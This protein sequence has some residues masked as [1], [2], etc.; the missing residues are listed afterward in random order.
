MKILLLANTDWFL[1][2]FCS[3][4]AQALRDRGDELVLASPPGD[5]VEKLLE[6]GFLWRPFPM[7]RRVSNPFAE[8]RTLA[9]LRSLVR[10]ERPDLVHHFTLKCVLYGTL[11]SRQRGRHSHRRGT[12]V[13]VNSITGLGYLYSSSGWRVRILRAVV[14]R[15]GR[16]LLP[17]THSIFL[18][19]DDLAHFRRRGIVSAERSHLILG[20]GVDTE[21]YRPRENDD[22]VTRQPP[23]VAFVGRLL[24]SKGVGELVEAARRLRARGVQARFV[25][26]GSGDPGNPESVPADAVRGWEHEDLVESWGFSEDMMDTYGRTSVVCLPTTYR[27]GVPTVLLEAAACGRPVVAT[28]MP[29]CREAVVDGETGRLVAPGDAGALDEALAELI[30]D[31]HLRVRMGRA[32]RER[33]RR[34]LDVRRVV[35]ATLEVYR[36]AGL[37]EN[38]REEAS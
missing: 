38:V 35:E 24:W 17:S 5:H 26:V 10:R 29:G 12:P 6:A 8:L 37:G 18:N 11:V 7:P 34:E 19:R 21:V 15:I 25:L 4:L 2:R 1:Y 9:T 33:V 28:D 31:P 23:V 13:I 20:S 32:G 3:E 16:F 30:A 36:Q 27:E 22:G 14:E